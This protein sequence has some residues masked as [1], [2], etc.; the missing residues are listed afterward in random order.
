MGPLKKYRKHWADAHA[1]IDALEATTAEL[2]EAVQQNRRLNRRV[3]E[4]TD[5]V[6]ELLIPLAQSQDPA[7]VERLRA[8]QSDVL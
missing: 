3:A 7:V 6:T 1:R 2:R 4:L 5:V 8:Y